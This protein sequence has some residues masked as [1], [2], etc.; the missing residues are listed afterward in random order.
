LRRT[1]KEAK[2]IRDVHTPRDFFNNE[3]IEEASKK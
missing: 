1:P 2:M 3:I